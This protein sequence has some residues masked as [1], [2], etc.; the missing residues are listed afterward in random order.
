MITHDASQVAVS[1]ALK[2]IA[3][4]DKVLARPMMIPMEAA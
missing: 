2:A 3:G 4:S 1:R